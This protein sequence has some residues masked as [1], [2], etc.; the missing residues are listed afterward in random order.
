MQMRHEMPATANVLTSGREPR[1]FS[2]LCVSRW[3][4]LISFVGFLSLPN[5]GQGEDSPTGSN[6]KKEWVQKQI[7]KLNADTLRERAAAERDLFEA[8]PQILPMLPPPELLP[9]ASVKQAV[10]RVR[11]RLEEAKARES[12]KA[13]RVTLKETTPLE[14]ILKAITQQTGNAIN[15]SA[16]SQRMRK[17]PVSVDV[18]DEPFWEVM[19]HL[20][21]DAG[22]VLDS[23]ETGNAKQSALVLKPA[24]AA[25]VIK[26]LATA[27]R[28]AFRMQVDPL[29]LRPRFGKEDRQLLRVPFRLSAEPRLRPLFLKLAGKDFSA[30]TEAGATL[31]PFNPAE[32]LELPLGE[33][34]TEAG[35]HM[36][37]E[38]PKPFQAAVIELTGNAVLTVAADS[39]DITFTDLAK[40]TGAARRRGGVTVTLN[41]VEFQPDKKNPGRHS[42]HVRLT[43]HYDTGGPAF[44]S[45]RT[46]IFH[47]RVFL[48]DAQGDQI[49]RG[50]QYRTD[51]QTDGGVMVEYNFTNLAGDKS[52][53]KLTYVAPTLIIDVPLRFG[54]KRLAVPKS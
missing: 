36:D 38:V 45:H 53:Y 39:E 21:K 8:G 40:S 9:N 43:V 50:H 30:R 19:E 22:F 33:G 13:A 48:E 46:W 35:F 26:P 31:D 54:F 42:A 49:E 12:V 5:I 3:F 24:D 52:D 23:S 32:K 14:K 17:R 41:E 15:A 4:L 18:S 20:A 37:Y 27:N 6:V 11:L 10:R 29:K 51:L 2:R 34:G 16:L 25:G 44:E 7:A 1:T 47:N 28:M